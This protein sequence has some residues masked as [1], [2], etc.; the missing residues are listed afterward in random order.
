MVADQ[1]PPAQGR[2]Q[3]ADTDEHAVRD[4]PDGVLPAQAADVVT[5]NVLP[6]LRSIS[7]REYRASWDEWQADAQ[8]EMRFEL[9]DL[10]VRAGDDTAFAFGLL[11]CGGTQPDGKTICDTVRA[12]LCL[13]KASG[14]WRGRSIERRRPR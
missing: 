13:D 1:N 9:A 11:Q 3:M 6:P 10:V 12:T 5:F 7:A 8:C 14:P 2:L 4:L